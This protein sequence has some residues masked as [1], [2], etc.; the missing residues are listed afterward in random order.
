MTRVLLAVFLILSLAS[1]G[2][3]AMGGFG[4]AQTPDSA[5]GI[6]EEEAI[7]LAA[8]HVPSTDATLVGAESGRAD[9][10]DPSLAEGSS[11]LTGDLMVWVVT[12]SGTF[13]RGCP[14]Q[15]SG[16]PESSPRCES[17][18]EGIHRVILDFGTGEFILGRT[19]GGG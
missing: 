16:G 6:S 4:T 14:A 3:A 2:G 12:Y 15:P 13:P 18:A 9:D 19:E 17:M 5:D 8:S 1:C 11:F 10:I 7:S